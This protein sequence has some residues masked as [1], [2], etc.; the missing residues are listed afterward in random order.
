MSPV[1]DP[2]ELGHR[3]LIFADDALIA[4]RSGVDRQVH[5]CTKLPQPVLEPEAPWEMQRVYL[6]G[7]VIRD[8]ETGLFRMWYM[9]RGAADDRRDKRLHH[10]PRDLV[11]YATSTDG[12]SW[13][14]PDLGTYEYGGSTANNIV[15]DLHSP[16]VVLAPEGGDPSTRF[17]M[18]GCHRGYRAAVSPDGLNWADVA[19]DPILPH[20]DTITLMRDSRTGEH[21]VFHKIN[22]EHRGHRRR[23]V[24]L[25]ASADF[26]KWSEPKLVLAP[27]EEDD[28]WADKPGQRADFYNM[29]AFP[30]GGQFL[31]LVTVFR[32]RER[33]P[34]P[35]PEQS[36]D[37]GPID[38]QLAHSRDG[39]HW[40]RCEDRRPVIPNGPSAFDE[41]CILGV[42]NTPVVVE[43]EMWMY[44][45]AINTT[46]GGPMPPKRCTIGRAVW[47]RDG[48]VSLSAGNRSGTVET[49][50]LPPMGEKLVVN[51][52]ASGGSVTVEL[53]SESGAP[54]NGYAA[55]DC[56]EIRS[57]SVHHEVRW[58][59]ADRVPAAAPVRLRF[60]VRNS[61]LYAVSCEPS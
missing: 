54:L 41:G 29:S 37:D 18:V 33:N 6:Y 30:W 34:D 14:R 40:K 57:D 27:D 23:L 12:I 51:A 8:P 20:G 59:D 15:F 24:Y 22:A 7:T 13:E 38:V 10:S 19:A 21:L 46:H 43:D 50:P 9:S 36:P 31:G 5:P 16:S 28:A 1:G 56:R 53:L 48:L 60:H 26:R 44:Y 32:V 58:R 52:D 17:R 11:L 42:S 61:H 3:P 35:G 47:R 25:S 39:R 4:S 45:T 49:V 55:E 2:I